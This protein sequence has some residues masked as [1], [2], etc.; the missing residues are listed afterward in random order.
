MYR[1]AKCRPLTPQSM[2]NLAVTP[3][4]K[5]ILASKAATTQMIE[6]EMIGFLRS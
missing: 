5:H 1:R 2:L 4:L 3:Y 6:D